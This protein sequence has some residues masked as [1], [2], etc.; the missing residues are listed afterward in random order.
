MK[1][2][3]E[4]ISYII[5]LRIIMHSAIAKCM[6]KENVSHEKLRRTYP[7]N[8]ILTTNF[9]ALHKCEMHE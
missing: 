6:I 8:V 7:L 5:L 4:R 9:Y 1:N 3:G 2:Y